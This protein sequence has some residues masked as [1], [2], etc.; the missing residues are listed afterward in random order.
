M[1]L[2]QM[3]WC[4]GKNLRS[5]IAHLKV[6][7]GEGNTIRCGWF[8][9]TAKDLFSKLYPGSDSTEFRFQPAGFGDFLDSG[10]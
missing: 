3:L 7:G 8:R 10:I 5:Y 4:R 1:C 2:D 6:L 9:W